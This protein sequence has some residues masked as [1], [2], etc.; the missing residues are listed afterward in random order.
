MTM[1]KRGG[2]KTISIYWFAILVIVAAAIIYMVAFVYGKPYDIRNAESEILSA[3]IAG[4]LSEGGYLKDGIIGNSSFQQNFLKTC[5]INLETP[6]FPETRGEYYIGVIFYDFNTGARIN[7]EVS[8]GND[9][10]KQ[11]CGL[12]G[13]T[14]PVC[15]NKS[16]YVIDKIQKAYAINIISIVNKVDKNVQ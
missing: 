7:P 8:E 10:L 16:F 13:E 14:N 1:N 15:T 12:D 11:Y 6:D 9:N 4:C 2:E 5:R 3:N